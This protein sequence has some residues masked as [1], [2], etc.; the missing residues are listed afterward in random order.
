MFIHVPFWLQNALIVIFYDL[1]FIEWITK[2]KP[3]INLIDVHSQLNH[4]KDAKDGVSVKGANS[5]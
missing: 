1:H 2:L 4:N 5:L 3:H